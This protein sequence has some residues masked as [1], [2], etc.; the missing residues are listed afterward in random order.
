VKQLQ[1][2]LRFLSDLRFL[3]EPHPGI[4]KPRDSGGDDAPA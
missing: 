1:F 4:N 3:L 2:E